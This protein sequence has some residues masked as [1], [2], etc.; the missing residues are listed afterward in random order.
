MV[1]L[2]GIVEKQTPA[3][4]PNRYDYFLALI[5]ALLSSAAIA[6][7]FGSIPVWVSTTIS[8]TVAIFIVGL[9]LA[10]HPT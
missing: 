2:L 3:D 1:R 5:P 8:S 7:W 10:H 6:T 9:A 4:F